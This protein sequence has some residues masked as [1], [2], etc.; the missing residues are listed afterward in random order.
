MRADDSGDTCL[1]SPCWDY[2]ATG[3]IVL[4]GA[5]CD[6]IKSSTDAKIEIQVGCVT[7]IK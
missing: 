3:Q 4:I 2:D 6:E 7:L 5:A 1:S